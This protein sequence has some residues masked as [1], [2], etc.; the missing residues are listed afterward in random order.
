MSLDYFVKLESKKEL[1][2]ERV[3]II[4]TQELG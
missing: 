3:H 4:G 2:K 1:K